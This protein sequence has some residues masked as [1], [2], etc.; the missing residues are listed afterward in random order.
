[1]SPIVCFASAT[2]TPMHLQA[3]LA[4]LIQDA[5]RFSLAAIVETRALAAL[6]DT[7][8]AAARWNPTLR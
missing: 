1:M 5:G 6:A 8:Q 3:T 4:S 2:R 7:S